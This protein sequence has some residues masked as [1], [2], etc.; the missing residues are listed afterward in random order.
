M[1]ILRWV[2]IESSLLKLQPQNAPPT[3]IFVTV[4]IMLFIMHSLAVEPYSKAL[5]PSQAGGQLC[6]RSWSV[7]ILSI[8]S[9]LTDVT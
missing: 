4:F 7:S 8:E 3:G 6:L 2:H 9:R 1:V 5:I